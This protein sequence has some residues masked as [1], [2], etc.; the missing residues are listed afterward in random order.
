M[1][2]VPYY[3]LHFDDIDHATDWVERFTQY[4]NHRPHSSICGYTPQS[5][6]DGTWHTLKKNRCAAIDN[7]LAKRWINTQPAPPKDLPSPVTIIRTSTT[8]TPQ[9]HTIKNQ[10]QIVHNHLT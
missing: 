7:A 4:Y 8:P 5:V 6:L 3:P 10:P 9:P 1:K 2:G